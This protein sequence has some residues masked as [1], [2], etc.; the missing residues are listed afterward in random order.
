MECLNRDVETRTFLR[1]DGLIQHL[2]HYHSVP[3]VR[4]EVI[5]AW[6]IKGLK[7]EQDWQCGFCGEMSKG[8]DARAVHITGHFR[9]GLGMESWRAEGQRV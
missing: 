6:E 9:E 5:D 1:R 4:S 7:K 3:Q 2:I 8:W